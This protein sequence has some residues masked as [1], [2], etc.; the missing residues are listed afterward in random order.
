MQRRV[1][2]CHRP[3]EAMA[4]AGQCRIWLNEAQREIDRL[5]SGLADRVVRD[6]VQIGDAFCKEPEPESKAVE[7][8]TRS[9]APPALGDVS[10]YEPVRLP[11]PPP[12]MQEMQRFHITSV[13]SLLDVLA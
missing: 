7:S 6:T 10:E 13:G 9:Y 1:E 8:A 2:V 3:R 12:V 4:D 11:P 5:R